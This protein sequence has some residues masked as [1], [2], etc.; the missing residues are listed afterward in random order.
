MYISQDPIRLRSGEPALYAY[1]H[2]PNACVD[3]FGLEKCDLD[4]DDM[5]ILDSTK[6]EEGEMENPHRHHIVR[7]NAPSNWKNQEAIDAVNNSHAILEA[8]GID[9]NKDI[10]NFCWA[11]NG[12]RNHSQAAAIEVNS[13][14]QETVNSNKTNGITGPEAD[15]NVRNTLKELGGEFRGGT[16]TR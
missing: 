7:E 12:D 16:I 13:R 3:R 4:K 1:V 8:H 15:Q 2:N 14:L 10:D 6:P 11:Q 5:E 9:K